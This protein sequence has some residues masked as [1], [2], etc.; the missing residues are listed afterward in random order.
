M[1]KEL[2][3]WNIRRRINYNRIYIIGHSLGAQ[4]GAQVARHLKNNTFWKIE[5]ITGLDPAKPCFSK[6]N[7][8]LKLGPS[9]ANFVDIIHTQTTRSDK[10]NSLGT[11]ER[12]GIY[13]FLRN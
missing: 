10:I 13:D 2:S 3:T 12:L 5:R 11:A 4:L 1:R 7:K 9:D 8:H 6:I